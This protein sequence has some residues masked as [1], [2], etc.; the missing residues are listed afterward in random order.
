MLH[1]AEVHILY[2]LLHPFEMH[3]SRFEFALEGGN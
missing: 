1:H 3:L 2:C